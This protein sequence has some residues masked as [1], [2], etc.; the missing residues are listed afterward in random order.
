MFINQMRRWQNTVSVCSIQ[1]KMPTS[2]KIEPKMMSKQNTGDAA[3][4]TAFFRAV[5]MMMAR[6]SKS[7]MITPAMT[8]IGISIV[9]ATNK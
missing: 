6:M 7:T 3:A 9:L 4:M 2:G 1:E 8:A 5:M